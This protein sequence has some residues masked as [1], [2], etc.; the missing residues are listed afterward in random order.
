MT[1]SVSYFGYTQEKNIPDEN[2]TID[3]KTYY[4]KRAAEDAKYEQE[5][6]A[7]NKEEE[8]TFWDE[9]KEYEEDL[10]KRDRKAYRAYM[11]G[12]KDAYAEHYDHCNNHCH[13]SHGYYQHASF[14]YYGYNNYYYE[15]YPK[16]RS[17]I[18]TGVRVNAPSV[19]LGIF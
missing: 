16:Q 4:Q 3:K 13:H 18:S 1:M 19:R 9:Q 5:F 14:Y 11:Q 2:N 10:K 15:R 8:D 6:V 7:E 12:K 17:T